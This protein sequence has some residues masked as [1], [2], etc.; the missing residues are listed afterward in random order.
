M[1]EEAKTLT[2]AEILKMI[3]ESGLD[4][5]RKDE[6]RGVLPDMTASEKEDLVHILTGE[7]LADDPEYQARLHELN[8][9]YTREMDQLVH[10]ETEKARK[11]FEAEEKKAKAGEMKELE[12]EIAAAAPG[13]KDIQPKTLEK[14]HGHPILKILIFLL[15]LAAIAGGAVYGLMYFGTI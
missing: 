12:S 3:D 9:K 2:D 10:D 15:I 7:A 14:K 11:A 1:A 13:V 8:E 6:L 4:D 5:A